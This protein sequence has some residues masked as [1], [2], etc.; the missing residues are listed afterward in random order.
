MRTTLPRGRTWTRTGAGGTVRAMM[1]PRHPFAAARALDDSLGVR[2]PIGLFGKYALYA[3]I[4]EGALSEVFLARPDAFVGP[5]EP[6]ALKRVKRELCA[7]VHVI[8]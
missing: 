8:S 2:A 5:S 4:G 6:C 1:E 3:M 7:D